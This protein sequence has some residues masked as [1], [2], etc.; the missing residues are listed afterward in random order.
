MKNSH[1]SR[2]GL[3]F[4]LLSLLLSGVSL[5]ANPF[6][7]HVVVVVEENHGFSDILGPSNS[8]IAH[9]SIPC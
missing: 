4:S 6:Y 9:T 2:K 3:V 1:F 5:H 7:D 8:A